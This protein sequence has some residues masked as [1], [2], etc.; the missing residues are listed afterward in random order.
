MTLKD[1]I[2]ELKFRKT[3]YEKRDPRQALKIYKGIAEQRRLGGFEDGFAFGKKSDDVYVSP[4]N[5]SGGEMGT[6]SYFEFAP[7]FR[8]LVS[9]DIG[10]ADIDDYLR[11]AATGIAINL[12][13]ESARLVRKSA[14]PQ[15]YEFSLLDFAANNVAGTIREMIS[16]GISALSATDQLETN[17]AVRE[18][19][20]KCLKIY[21]TA[22]RDHAF[23]VGGK[24]ILQYFIDTYENTRANPDR[25]QSRTKK[26]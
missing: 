22:E 23:T 3:P 16:D 6:F 10:N 13:R 5:Y 25:N 26:T 2:D 18:Q 19:V 21:E 24:P 8:G 9:G 11:G 15:D 14:G 17:P 20:V 7:I 1:I 12:L 4:E